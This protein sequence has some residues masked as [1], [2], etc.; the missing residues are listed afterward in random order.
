MQKIKIC[1]PFFISSIESTTFEVRGGNRLLL[2]LNIKLQDLSFFEF[3]SGIDRIDMKQFFIAKFVV[4]R[5]AFCKLRRNCGF[6]CFVNHLSGPFRKYM[7]ICDW[8]I[9]IHFVCFCVSRFAACDRRVSHCFGPG[10]TNFLR[11]LL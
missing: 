2:W 11:S 8:C 1:R 10:S 7:S 4:S 6:F 9:S 3:M 5:C